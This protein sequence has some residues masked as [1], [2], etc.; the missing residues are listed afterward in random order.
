MGVVVAIDG[1]LFRPCACFGLVVCGGRMV[2]TDL[3]ETAVEMAEIVE[4]ARFV[5]ATVGF[6]ESEWFEAAERAEGREAVEMVVGRGA[7]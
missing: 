6:E 5:S 4:M 2:T 7:R 3:A 1:G